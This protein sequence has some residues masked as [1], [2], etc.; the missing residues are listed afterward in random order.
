MNSRVVAKSL[1]DTQSTQGSPLPASAALWYLCFAGKLKII[2]STEIG[3]SFKFGRLNL[4][5]M[6]TSISN[7]CR[8]HTLV[9]MLTG[10]HGRGGK[11]W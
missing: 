7:V 4:P 8:N 11:I 9:F 1:V 5:R 2:V 10:A 3:I 6:V